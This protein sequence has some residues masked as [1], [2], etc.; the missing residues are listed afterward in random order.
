ML[1]DVADPKTKQRKC[2]PMLNTANMIHDDNLI[3][4]KYITPQIVI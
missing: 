2:N 1:V 3:Q 4:I